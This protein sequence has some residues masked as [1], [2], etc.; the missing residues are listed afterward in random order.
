MAVQEVTWKGYS[1][2]VYTM[3]GTW[4]KVA[5]IYIFT[6]LNAKNL[7]V[8]LYIGQTESFAE[9]LANHERWSEA[10]SL[11]ATH[12]HAKGVGKK[13]ERDQIEALLI[14]HFQP[15]LNVQLRNG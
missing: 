1:F 4:N 8:P 7:W 5:G 11:G 3:T 9:R 12:V 2:S 6:G 15:R 14:G 13:A 10:Q